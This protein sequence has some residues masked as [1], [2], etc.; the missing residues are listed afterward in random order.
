MNGTTFS[1]TIKF[2]FGSLSICGKDVSADIALDV[3]V[4]TAVIA[5]VKQTLRAFNHGNRVKPH[6]VAANVTLSLLL[7]RF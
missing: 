6:K 4:F 7:V 3:L 2:N 1:T 5:L